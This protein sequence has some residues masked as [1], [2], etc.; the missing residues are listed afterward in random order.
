MNQIISG[1]SFPAI[2]GTQAKTEYYIVM[3]PLKRLSKIFTFDE[4][5]LP[6]EQRAQRI[7]NEDRIPEITNYILDNRDNYV[8]SALTACIDGQSEFVSIG[9]GKHE[10]KIGT[11]VIDEDADIYITDGQHRHAAILEALKADPSLADESISV[12]F[13]IN[14]SLEER[15]RIFK[16]L[17]LYPVKT[18]SSLSITYDD[19]PDAKLSKSIIYE[20]DQLSKLV[21]MERSNLGPRSK[22]LVSHS[23]VNKAT[24]FL[25]GTITED[26][27]QKLIPVAATYWH[28]VI[29]NM[30]AWQLICDDKASGGE[31]R[32]E[33]INAHAVTFQALGFLGADL[34]KNEKNWKAKLAGL[35]NINWSRTNPDWQGRC[36]LN[37]SMHNNRKFAEL[38]YIQI[39]KLLNM[40][41]NEKENNI[42]NA[43]K[44]A[45]NGY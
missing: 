5:Q 16:D 44:G 14:K 6:V 42:E 30:P 32:D 10:Q 45:R 26:N 35:Q 31:L 40:P 22:K 11:L 34:L 20:S 2:R 43:F 19:K 36:V 12:V 23:A 37:G 1:T 21:H 39:K 38:T 27:Y 24:K 9:N 15:Q 25:L 41:L 18:D 13:F 8:F 7:I 28:E 3:C 29:K 33:A 4:G 17:N